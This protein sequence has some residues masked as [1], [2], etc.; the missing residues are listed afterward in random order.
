MSFCTVINCMDGRVQV[1]VI[2]Y[3]QDRFKADYVDSITE[4]GPN[5]VLAE[6]QNSAQVQSILDRLQ[7]SVEKHQSVGIAIVGHHDCAGNPAP[8]EKQ[9]KHIE[10]AVTRIGR[11]YANVAVIGLWV[12]QDWVVHEFGDSQR[13]H[14]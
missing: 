12:D 1:P 4:P 6:D 2:S 5:R 7:I 3:L 10:A 8:K 9:L 14:K 11:L 13:E